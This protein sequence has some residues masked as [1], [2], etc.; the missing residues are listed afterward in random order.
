MKMR[1]L[2]CGK[3]E[4]N[5][6]GNPYMGTVSKEPYTC[7]HCGFQCTRLEVDKDGERLRTQP[8]TI[9]ASSSLGG[10][11]A[12][13]GYASNGLASINTNTSS[14]SFA[15]SQAEETALRSAWD[16]MQKGDWDKAFGTLCQLGGPFKHPIEVSIYRN[17]CQAVRLFSLTDIPSKERCQPIDIL[18][19]N[20]SNLDYFLPESD[21][22]E[23]D[24]EETFK[25]YKRLYDVFMLLSN[26]PLQHTSK[27]LLDFI[28]LRRIMLLSSYAD[29]LELE[30]I[31]NHK[32]FNEYLKM[33]A[34]LLYKCLEL[35]KEEPT[36]FLPYFE[37]Q[38]LL[39]SADRKQIHAK[40]AQL[41]AQI[42]MTDK[43][44]TCPPL[45]PLPKVVPQGIV[46]MFKYSLAL[47]GALAALY[48]F[49]YI[50]SAIFT[51]NDLLELGDLAEL[52]FYLFLTAFYFA[53]EFWGKIKRESRW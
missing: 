12:L 43:T 2:Y 13:N 6:P 28:N 22:E 46:R 29:L 49:Y 26:L 34:Q 1:C 21:K 25:I 44:F 5:I 8:Y 48:C 47:S 40:I 18:I 24:K 11:S 17:A 23:S 39:P 51:K 14:N 19:N 36:K 9:S 37:E 33:D 16:L 27:S 30:T 38:L 4:L 31:G 41:K 20:I 52:V 32:H 50:G 53:A 7:D 35:A 10:Y 15:D 42:G 3:T 45:P